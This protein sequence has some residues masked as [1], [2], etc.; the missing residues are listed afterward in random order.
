MTIT[1]F[2][3]SINSISKDENMERRIHSS[4]FL[5]QV[6][7]QYRSKKVEVKYSTLNDGK[8]FS[9]SIESGWCESFSN[10]DISIEELAS[11]VKFTKLIK[12]F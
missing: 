6:W 2:D 5:F 1:V 4:Q 9:S 10:G 7:S 11:K 3:L 12:T 8:C